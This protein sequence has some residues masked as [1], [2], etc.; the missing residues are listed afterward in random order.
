MVPLLLP[1]TAWI[2]VTIVFLS[3]AGISVIYAYKAM[4][5]DPS[6][7]RLVHHRKQCQVADSGNGAVAQWNPQDPT[8]QCWICDIQVGTKSM[9]CKFCNKC[10]DRFDHHCM[11]TLYLRAVAKKS[12]GMGRSFGMQ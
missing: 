5:T 9:H 11:C 10:V 8:K 4:S 12:T 2:P 7:P 1:L 3:L 6:D